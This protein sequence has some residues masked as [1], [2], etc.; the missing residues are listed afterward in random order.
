MINKILSNLEQF[1]QFLAELAC[2]RMHQ[3]SSRNIFSKTV[4]KFLPVQKKVD[5]AEH[6]LNIFKNYV[7]KWHDFSKIYTDGSKTTTNVG[8]GI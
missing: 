3:N 5:S 8:C 1:R 7:N 2:M 6:I 4:V